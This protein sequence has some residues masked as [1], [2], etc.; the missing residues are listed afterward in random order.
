M[1]CGGLSAKVSYSIAKVC[2]AGKYFKKY[3]FYYQ[4][5]RPVKK[6]LKQNKP[7]KVILKQNISVNTN[8]VLYEIRY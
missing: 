6:I 8:I 2:Y 3:L 4:K 5:T 7:K 1:C